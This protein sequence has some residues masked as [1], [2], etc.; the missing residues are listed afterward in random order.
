MIL[1]I[2]MTLTLLW[3][4]NHG[5]QM[6]YFLVKSFLPIT[7]FSEKTELANMVEECFW[8]VEIHCHVQTYV[9]PTIVRQL[10]VRYLYIT[11]EVASYVPSI[12]HLAMT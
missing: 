12:G 8:H 3:G 6:T 5:L 4:V 1:F 11:T 9:L 10:Y 2:L 7:Q